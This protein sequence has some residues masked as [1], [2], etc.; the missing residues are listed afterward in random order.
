ML[1]LLQ[2]IK[3][4]LIIERKTKLR[5]ALLLATAIVMFAVPLNFFVEVGANYTHAAAVGEIEFF[6]LYSPYFWIGAVSL[7]VVTTALY[8]F[9][10]PILKITIDQFDWKTAL[11]DVSRI[12]KEDKYYIDPDGLVWICEACDAEFD[13]VRQADIHLE[14]CEEAEG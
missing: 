10:F 13:S 3:N 9:Y 7:L 1:S 12:A 6:D 5:N 11:E 14:T 8:K 2:E 4:E